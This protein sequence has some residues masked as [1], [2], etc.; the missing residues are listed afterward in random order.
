MLFIQ[1]LFLLATIGSYLSEA[2]PYVYE[3]PTKI[4]D[5]SDPYNTQPDGT[6]TG[7]APYDCNRYWLCMKMP[8]GSY[9]WVLEK[10]MGN[11]HYDGTACSVGTT[12][13]TGCVRTTKGPST[14]PHTP[15][16]T[17]STPSPSTCNE[18]TLYTTKAATTADPKDTNH[19]WL[20]MK[21]SSGGYEWIL[22]KC[23]GTLVYDPTKKSC[24]VPTKA[25]GKDSRTTPA[26]N[27]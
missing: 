19:Y 20:C 18:K 7:T 26:Y 2:K 22:E 17:P 4:C 23:M 24:Q 5:A 25:P 3:K 13:T 12:P 8:D 16:P 11:L 27:P 9:D 14:T 15:R 21:S 6:K 10:C 1:L